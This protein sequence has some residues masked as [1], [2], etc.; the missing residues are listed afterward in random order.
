MTLHIFWITGDLRFAL[1]EECYL[2]PLTK[3]QKLL[4][5]VLYPTIIVADHALL[6]CF[7]NSTRGP[8][9]ELIL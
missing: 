8:Y 1:R 7:Q 5:V 2:V 4:I 9:E 3:L 6:Y